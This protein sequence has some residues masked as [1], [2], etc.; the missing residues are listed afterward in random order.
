MMPTQT[1]YDEQV[2]IVREEF[3]D[4]LDELINTLPFSPECRHLKPHRPRPIET[5][6]DLISWMLFGLNG[7]IGAGYCWSYIP[8]FLWEWFGKGPDQ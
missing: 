5:E 4:T 3:G 6:D 7:W 1:W 2:V 8:G